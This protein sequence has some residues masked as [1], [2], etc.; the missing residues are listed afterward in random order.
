MFRRYFQLA[1]ALIYLL[2]SS[3]A[4]AALSANSIV[5]IQSGATAGNVNGG[6][7]N[8]TNAN[9][10]TDLATTT[11]TSATP[12]VTSATYSFVTADEGDWLYV[13]SGTNWTAGWYQI[14]STSG[15]A[16]TINAAVGAAVQE[17]T[18]KGWPSPRF[19][20][21]TVQG[22]ATQDTPGGNGTFTVD[23]SQ[24]TGSIL[25]LSDFASVNGSAVVT[26]ATGGFTPVMV[27]NFWRLASG[28][29]ATAG[30]YEVVSYTSGTQ[31][32]VDRDCAG[33]ADLASGVGRVG[34][35]MS[36]ASTLDDDL[37]EIAVNATGAAFRYFIKNGSYD[38]GETVTIAAAGNNLW[39]VTI[40]GYNALRGDT[41]TGSNR[42]SITDAA[43]WTLG[44]SWAL[45][46]AIITNTAAANA[47]IAGDQNFFENIKVVATAGSATALNMT[48]AGGICIRCEL[49][50]TRGNGALLLTGPNVIL[51][52]YIHDSNIGVG[53]SGSS[54]AGFT[55]ANSVIADNVTAAVSTTGGSINDLFIINSTLYGAENKLG[56]GV[57]QTTGTIHTRIFNT[58]LYG[59][60]SGVIHETTTDIGGHDDF[61]NFYNN[62]T[63]ATRW[64]KGPNT[65]GLDPAFGDTAQ[66][67]GTGATSSTNVLTVGSGTPFGGIEDNV[68]IVYLSAG[69][70]TG[71]SLTKY[72]ITA[73]TTT[74]LTL[75]RNITSSGAGTG[76]T[77]QVTTGHNFSVGANMKAVGFPGALQG[78][79][80]SGTTGYMD[81]GA[82]QRVES[83][84][85]GG[86]QGFS[87][88]Q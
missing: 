28:T 11:G 72:L 39:P 82:I 12:S 21:N 57:N 31:V 34:G 51:G 20:A 63:D 40:E 85:G 71:I 80:A 27:G 29:N 7:F 19:K 62:T 49:I 5:E 64:P 33:A 78:T 55:I 32:T 1:L 81:I 59:F 30:W 53:W 65:I 41:P 25:S 16:A 36:M 58:I 69:S 66:L 67:T 87:Y 43:A 13:K 6:G 46:N 10:L 14:T 56:I 24:S 86:L 17:D 15:G 75:D 44:T 9:M 23:Y 18:T 22:V 35:A 37:F 42:P 73:H 8:R 76:I 77:W 26:T 68:D 79:G 54:T 52:S 50:A 70:G 45:N 2:S 4:Q 38:W 61:N 60:T 88:S 3:V 74:T 83:T 48:P 84:G 47:L